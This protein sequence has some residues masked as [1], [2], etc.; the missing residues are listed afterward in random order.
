MEAFTVILNSNVIIERY[1]MYEEVRRYRVKLGWGAVTHG[2]VLAPVPQ[3]WACL[4]KMEG[5]QAE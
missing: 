4:R 3:R 1:E 2:T 5:A